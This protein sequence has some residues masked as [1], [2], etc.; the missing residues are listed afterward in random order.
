MFYAEV[1][2]NAALFSSSPL[3]DMPKRLV[4]AKLI[5]AINRDSILQYLSLS[6]L[7]VYVCQWHSLSD[8]SDNRHHWWK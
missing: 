8:I 7:I 2:S 6:I 5:Q 3:A 1:K 4:I